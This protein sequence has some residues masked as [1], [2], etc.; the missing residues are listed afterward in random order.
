M[1]LGQGVT[2]SK[3]L[4]SVVVEN[5]KDGVSSSLEELLAAA[6][7]NAIDNRSEAVSVC[8]GAKAHN[9]KTAAPPLLSHG[10]WAGLKPS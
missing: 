4:V 10:G 8:R 5:W 1:V 9:A 7:R 2:I 6:R 3:V